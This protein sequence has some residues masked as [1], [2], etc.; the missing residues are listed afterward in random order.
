MNPPNAF[1]HESG[2]LEVGQGHHV[3]YEVSGN[4]EGLPALFLHGG[5][6]AP[7]TA[8]HRKNFDPELYRLVSL[9]QRGAGLSTPHAAADGFDPAT[10]ATQL[11]VDDVE[12]LRQHLGIDRWLV[13]GSSWGSTLALYA[14]VRNPAS[15]LGLVLVAV[16]TTSPDEVWWITEGVGRL[17]PEAWDELAHHVERATPWRRGHGALIDAVA[18]VMATGTRVER[19]AMARAWM[20]W[21]DT[22]VQ[23]GMPV[24]Q[25][26]ERRLSSWDE[27]A[28]IAFTT[29]VSAT[30]SRHAAG[31][32]AWVGPA[33]LAEQ[34][35]VLADVPLVMVHGRRD[36]S[37]PTSI[38]WEVKGILP[39]AE[40]HVV[41]HEGH[42]G[43]LVA[44]LWDAATTHFAHA[45]TFAGMTDYL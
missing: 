5:P 35:P 16:T 25:L 2:L 37:G 27:D 10:C 11:L 26:R 14:A 21:E 22:H 38:P 33:P 23:V 30:W 43:P 31:D 32:P 24:G 40:L 34:L 28:A 41:E 8:G 4:P 19:A 36:V 18:G 3:Y 1:P 42:G 44:R 29:L 17:Y 9:Q 20:A 45:G 12:A 39:H 7:L 6:G 15:I 13:V